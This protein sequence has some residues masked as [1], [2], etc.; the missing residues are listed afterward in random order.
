MSDAMP[1]ELNEWL[2]NHSA[3]AALVWIVFIWALAALLVRTAMK[4]WPGLVSLV[5]FI[6]ALGK[7][8]EFMQT[9]NQALEDLA[10]TTQEVK[11]EVFPNRG[12]SMR[13]DLTEQALRMQKIEARLEKDYRR[14]GEIDSQLSE[15]IAR[16][17]RNYPDGV[18]TT[19]S[20]QIES[21][22]PPFPQDSTED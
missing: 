10:E 7:L 11:H 18:P 12:G 6:Q 3:M 9:T 2:N 4:T 13:D 21:G 8:P 22:A 15:H 19:G 1:P 16:R 14:L 5:K 17:E 20:L